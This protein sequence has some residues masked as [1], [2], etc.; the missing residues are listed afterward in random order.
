MLER[1]A[2][3]YGKEAAAKEKPNAPEADKEFNMWLAESCKEM[4]LEGEEFIDHWEHMID[5]WEDGYADYKK[6]RVI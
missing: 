2:K 1:I 6:G 4:E 5:C 3:F